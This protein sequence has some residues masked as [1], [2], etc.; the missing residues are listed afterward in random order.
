MRILR[1]LMYNLSVME[2]NQNVE[3]KRRKC[4]GPNRPINIHQPEQFS[5]AFVKPCPVT[6][7]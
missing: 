2:S 3:S 4:W 5:R 7:V 6:P 1:I